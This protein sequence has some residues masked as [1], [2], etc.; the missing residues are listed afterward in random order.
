MQAQGIEN[1]VLEDSSR[2]TRVFIQARMSSVR[3]PGKVLAPFRKEPLILHVLRAVKQIVGLERIVVLTSV[4]V[5]D[6]PL[7]A[8]LDTLSIQLFRGPLDNVFE[9]FQLCAQKFP[10]DWIMR[11]C[12]DSPLFDIKVLK[13][14]MGYAGSRDYDLVTTIFPRTFPKG[15]NVELIRSTAL[16][17]INLADLLPD[18]LE[19]VTPYFYR[20]AERFRILNI[21]S[22]NPQPTSLSLSVDSIEDLQRLE[23]MK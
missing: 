12:A 17:S 6:D 19:H 20:R 1:N 9:R 15:Q 21:K 5:S 11:L 2:L 3:F 23:L 7:V 4:E 18:D 8:Y 22:D 10:C 13:K 14:V 16:M